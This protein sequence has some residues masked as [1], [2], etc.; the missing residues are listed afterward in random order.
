[1]LRGRSQE[2]R[3]SLSRTEPKPIRGFNS[4]EYSSMSGNPLSA[5]RFKGNQRLGSVPTLR[6]DLV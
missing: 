6:N 1:M 3:R 5:C 4:Q 2:H